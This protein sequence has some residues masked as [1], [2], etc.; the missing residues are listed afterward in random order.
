MHKKLLGHLASAHIQG[1]ILKH[2]NI[3]QTSW[4][5]WVKSRLALLQGTSLIHQNF[6]GNPGST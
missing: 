3:Y 5:G 2:H 4:I 6:L 1:L